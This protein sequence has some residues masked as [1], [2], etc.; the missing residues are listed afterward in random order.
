MYRAERGTYIAN[1]VCDDTSN[2]IAIWMKNTLKEC[3]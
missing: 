1:L 2:A 3:K